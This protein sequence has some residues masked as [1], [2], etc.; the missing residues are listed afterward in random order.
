[1][2][3]NNIIGYT[4]K[5]IDQ[6]HEKALKELY[7]LEDMTAYSST[8]LGKLITKLQGVKV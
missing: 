1:M 5:E 8:K 6:Q 2:K 7:Q 4:Q 3:G